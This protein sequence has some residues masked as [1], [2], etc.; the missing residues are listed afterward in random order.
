MRVVTRVLVIA[1]L[2]L[3]FAV[4]VP[5]LLG[6]IQTRVRHGSSDLGV[7]FT[8]VGGVGLVVLASIV[9][10]A[11]AT[12]PKGRLASA[13]SIAALVAAVLVMA[14]MVYFGIAAAAGGGS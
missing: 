6:D 7:W 11:L 4:G 9:A 2:V 12:R 5:L 14:A 10:I 1:Q 8:V 13:F 3:V